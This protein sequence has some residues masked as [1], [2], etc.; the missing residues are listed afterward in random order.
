MARLPVGELRA[1]LVLEGPV[2]TPDRAGGVTRSWTPLA[3]VWGDVA[4]L[5]AQQRLEADQI[6][7]TVTHRLTLRWRA[8]LSTKQRLRRG[9]QIFLIRGVQDPDDRRRRLVC[10]CEEI[11]P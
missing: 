6:G 9:S 1:R 5:N 7:Q 8:G 4:T 10:N 2:E 3:S 11:K